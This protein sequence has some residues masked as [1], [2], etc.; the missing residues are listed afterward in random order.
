MPKDIATAIITGPFF[1]GYV[2]Q[3]GSAFTSNGVRVKTVVYKPNTTL[4][5]LLSSLNIKKSKEHLLQ[6]TDK[7]NRN[8]D[9]SQKIFTPKERHDYFALSRYLN[10]LESFVRE[11]KPS[12]VL[13]VRPD[14]IPLDFFFDLRKLSPST[15]LVIWSTDPIRRF[16]VPQEMLEA[17]EVV[18]LYDK[19]DVA[20]VNAHR[21][22]GVYLPMGF[23][24]RAYYLLPNSKQELH[25]IAF[26]GRIS[27]ERLTD[28][29]YVANNINLYNRDYGIYGGYTNYFVRLRLWLQKDK[30]LLYAYSNYTRVN[31]YRAADIYRRTAVN[32]NIHQRGTRYGFNPRF[33]EIP[34]AGGFQIARYLP[35]MEEFFEPGKEVLYYES[36]T[37]LCELIKKYLKDVPE[38]RRISALGARRAHEQYSLKSRVRTLITHLS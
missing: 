31:A 34:A 4:I 29:A 23:D 16:F 30:P 10:Q 18:F 8:L 7:S 24:E 32:L 5:S 27:E 25:K 13:F 1:H 9:D 11:W 14:L 20:Y 15:K 38:R 36:A 26:I 17:C 21:A 6:N 33:F 19:E 12:L 35:G 28:L 37:D 3:I 2:E 22:N